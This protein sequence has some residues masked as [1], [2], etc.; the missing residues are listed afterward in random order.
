MQPRLASHFNANGTVNFAPG[1]TF[2]G[3]GPG[4]ITGVTAGTGL[5]G[6]GTTGNVTLNL[7]TTKV[8]T[9]VIAGTGLT[10]G[11]TGGKLTLAV[12]PT[13]VP[14]L[15]TSNTFGQNLTVAGQ[16]VAGIGAVSGGIVVPVGQNGVGS[17]NGNGFTL[18][19]PGSLPIRST[20]NPPLAIRQGVS[21]H[22]ISGGRQNLWQYRLASQAV[23]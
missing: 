2:P 11:G 22:W 6:G 20:C 1:Q 9:G 7:D 15:N 16:I 3:T 5:L 10:G 21:S 19:P 23:P 18:S 8:V 12:H 17:F 4:A 14:L 13:Q